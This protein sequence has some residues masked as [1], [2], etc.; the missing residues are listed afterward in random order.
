MTSKAN[1]CI[2]Q[3][4]KSG[5]PQGALAC[6]TRYR[7]TTYDHAGKRIAVIGNGS[8]GI[9][10]VAALQKSAGKLVN[11]LRNPTWI[12]FNVGGQ[13]TP[14]GSNFPYSDDQLKEFRESPEKFLAYRK[15][16]ES[17]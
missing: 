15:Q 1:S 5:L 3:G 4:G 14:T 2:V 12:S 9:Q 13:F 11:Y 7:D 10:L 8:S 16:V 6:L 17:A